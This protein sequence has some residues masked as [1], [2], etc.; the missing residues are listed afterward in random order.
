MCR[1]WLARRALTSARRGGFLSQ[2]AASDRVLPM[3]LSGL[4]FAHLALAH[5]FVDA[6][7]LVGQARVDFGA[8]WVVLVP[9]GGVRSGP[10]DA[11]ERLALCSSRPRA[12]LC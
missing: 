6:P 5:L 8:T 4:P 10:A 1:F 9:V 11:A 7:V 2:L 12:P 3:Q